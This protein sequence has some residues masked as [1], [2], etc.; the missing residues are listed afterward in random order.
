MQR[1]LDFFKKSAYRMED[2]DEREKH[3]K[4]ELPVW[5]QGAKGAWV[6]ESW[7]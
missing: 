7:R 3:P 5:A 4:E 6:A 1:M 2:Q